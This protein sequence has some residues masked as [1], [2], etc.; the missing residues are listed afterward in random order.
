MT[1][2]QPVGNSIDDITRN[3]VGPGPVTGQPTEQGETGVTDGEDVPEQT[4]AGNVGDLGQV[5][6]TDNEQPEG[7]GEQPETPPVNSSGRPLE[8]GVELED[9]NEHQPRL[10]YWEHVLEKWREETGGREMVYDN[11]LCRFLC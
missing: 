10:K 9:L 6:E 2:N 11:S 7:T 5:I 3:P 4:T 8:S 1:I